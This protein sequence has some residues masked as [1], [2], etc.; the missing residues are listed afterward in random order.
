MIFGEEILWLGNGPPHST[1]GDLP[2]HT[3]A[4]TIT[5]P[6]EVGAEVKAELLEMFVATQH[7]HILQ[8]HFI[9]F[10]KRVHLGW[11]GN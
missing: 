4:Q 2:A 3:A 5:A 6:Q 11:V 8:T 1:E 9:V 7:H 10:Y